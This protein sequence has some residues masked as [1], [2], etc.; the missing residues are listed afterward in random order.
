MTEKITRSSLLCSSATQF[1]P[2]RFF[3]LMVYWHSSVSTL[4]ELVGVV[5]KS[6]THH[7]LIEPTESWTFVS[8]LLIFQNFLTPYPIFYRTGTFVSKVVVLE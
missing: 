4:S 5:E 6:T 2:D 1:S 7:Q 3:G 8:G